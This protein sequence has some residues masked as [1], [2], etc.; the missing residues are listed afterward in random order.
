[1]YAMAYLG[2]HFGGSKYFCKSR[3]VCMAQSAMQRVAKHAFI[4]GVRGYAPPRISFKNGA[5][6]CVL[7]NILLKFVTK[8]CKNIH[9]LYKN[10]R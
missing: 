10:N 9:F 5:I 4:R 6:C 8:N 2:F 7:E 3:G 1:M